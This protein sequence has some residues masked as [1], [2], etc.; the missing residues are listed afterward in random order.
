MNVVDGHKLH[1]NT[2]LLEFVGEFLRLRKRHTRVLRAMDN[3]EW[4]IIFGDMKDRR[5]FLPNFCVLRVV[6]AEEVS[7][8]GI[9]IGIAGLLALVLTIL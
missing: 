3:Q 1:G 7:Q 8:K 6:P 2:R 9:V 5:S 4:G